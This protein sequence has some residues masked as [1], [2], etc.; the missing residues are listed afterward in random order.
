MIDLTVLTPTIPGRESLLAECIASVFAQNLPVEAHYVAARRRDGS[1][2][3]VHTAK[4][5]NSVLTAATT[6]WVCALDDDDL[7]L[8]HH[9]ETIV[10]ALDGADVVY[11]LD[12]DAH[13]PYEDCTDW[14]QQQLINRLEPG[15]FIAAGAAIRREVLLSVGGWPTDWQNGHYVGSPCFFEDWELWRT[16]ARVGAKFRCVPVKTWQY[17]PGDWPRMSTGGL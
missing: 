12:V 2:V 6:E 7:W 17:R 16:L 15:N 3:Q 4:Q 5:R 11:T 1:V 8:P 13:L 10:P 14:S 9:I